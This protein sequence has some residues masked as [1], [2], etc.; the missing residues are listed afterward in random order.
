MFFQKRQLID[1]ALCS[2]SVVI[3]NDHI[4]GELLQAFHEDVDDVVQ[5]IV[6]SILHEMTSWSARSS[7]A[8]YCLTEAGHIFDS[9][10]AVLI[11]HT[12]GLCD[13]EHELV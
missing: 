7:R 13:I 3:E 8:S 4:V 10:N 6:L 2:C 12:V 5:V 1:D 11:I 9:F